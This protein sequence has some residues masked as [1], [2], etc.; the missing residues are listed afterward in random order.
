MKK[1]QK[2]EGVNIYLYRKFYSEQDSQKILENLRDELEWRKVRVK[3]FG[4]EYTSPRLSCWYGTKPY[5]YSG[6][7]W[8]ERS[9]TRTLL[10]IKR[11][12]EKLT[13]KKFNGVL[14]NLYRNGQDSMGWHSD[15]E[16]ELGDD[17]II[18]S[19]VLGS[20]R[21]FMIREK[22]I[23]KNKQQIIFES[24]DV[25]I[26]GEGVQKKWEHSVPKTEKKLGMRVNLTF[27]DIY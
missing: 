27:R 3:L 18:V 8:K 5:K 11:D 2:I 1:K 9:W 24:G 4:K 10:K 26:M 13:L 25:M 17:P 6:Y 7:T 21:R 22:K 14:V 20:S 15:N 16:K 23:K 19:L 12:I